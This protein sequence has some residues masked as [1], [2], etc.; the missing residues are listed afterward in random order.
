MCARKFRSVI[1]VCSLLGVAVSP[2]FLFADEK[3]DDQ[4]TK[5]IT[6]LIEMLASRNTAP[7]I[8][9]TESKREVGNHPMGEIAQAKFDKAY[10]SNHQ[11]SVYLAMQQLL[12]EEETALDLLLKY[13]DDKRYCLSL[14]SMENDNNETVGDV[15]Q[16]LFRAKILPFE[17]E[18]LFMT[19]DQRGVYPWSEKSKKE[20]WAGKKKRG[21]AKVQIE[22]I[23]AM[24]AFM[25]KADAKKALAS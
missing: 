6:H 12:V 17:S 10:E 9:G 23:D 16:R 3:P 2:A 14:Y 8:I 18:L 1:C 15:C 19:K 5:R 11:V 13:T 22:A 4:A 21:L 25:R 24:L 7:R 20:W